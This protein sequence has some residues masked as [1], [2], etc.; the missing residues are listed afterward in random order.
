MNLLNWL[1]KWELNS[2][3]I[4]AQFLE[5]EVKFNQADRNAAWEMYIELLTRI[6]TQYLSPE[7]GDEEAALKSIYSIFDTTR[8]ILKK[9][10]KDC[11]EFAKI[12]II[13]LNQIIR[14]FTAKWHKKSMQEAFKQTEECNAFREELSNLQ[15]QLRN[16]TKLLSDIAEVE[17]LTDLEK[18]N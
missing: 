8:Q 2:L 6:T 13:V 16:Y 3:K 1:K 12:A 14:P 17:D 7:S 18:M 5:L 9:H 15:T 4:N 10:G 11:T